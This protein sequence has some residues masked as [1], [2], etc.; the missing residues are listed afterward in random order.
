MLLK[1]RILSGAAWTP[2]SAQ[3]AL[4]LCRAARAAPAR[5]A[6]AVAAS[7]WVLWNVMPKYVKLV[8]ASSLC[9]PKQSLA[10]SA[11]RCASPCRRCPLSSI[12]LVLTVLTV[13]P[14]RWQYRC[15]KSSCCCS[16][17]ADVASRTI[18]SAYSSGGTGLS[19]PLKTGRSS[20]LPS[21][22]AANTAASKSSMYM[23]NRVGLRGHPCFTPC[24]AWKGAATPLA[25]RTA[26]GTSAYSACTACSQLPPSPRARNLRH[27]RR[28]GT[29]S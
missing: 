6:T 14:W 21:A 18:S 12:S 19:L 26:M 4:H 25:V 17:A 22:A 1:S 16:P 20:C 7:C 11:A 3:R 28:R 27:R 13:R 29:L 9:P 2:S 5:A 15:S 23:P 10:A 8:T 24:R